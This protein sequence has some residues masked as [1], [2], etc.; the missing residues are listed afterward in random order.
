MLADGSSLTSADAALTLPPT[1]LLIT[2][3]FAL[4]VMF[5]VTGPFT[6]TVPDAASRSRPIEPADDMATDPVIATRSLPILLFMFISF[7]AARTELLILP[8]I[9]IVEAATVTLPFTVP[10][11]VTLFPTAITSPFTV[12]STVT[13]DPAR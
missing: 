7:P 4:Q 11:I 3:L 9:V 13:S 8:L 12:P 2:S 10:L 5:L 1:L 6:F